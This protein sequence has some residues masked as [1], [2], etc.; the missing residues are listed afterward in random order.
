MP[1][2]AQGIPERLLFESGFGHK[3]P[4]MV[5]FE[6]MSIRMRH[7]SS[8]SKNRRSHHALKNRNIV[9][10]E[11]GT[12]RLP[13]R[14]DEATGTYRGK[15]I[16][17]KRVVKEKKKDHDKRLAEHKHEHPEGEKAPIHTEKI[18]DAPKKAGVLG[19]M[20]KDRARSRSGFGG[21]A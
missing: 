16:V 14:V 12:L 11:D 3:N 21:G 17:E 13:H 5:G 1:A 18:E 20:M 19:R 7:T 6:P 2:A 15:Q 8:H 10:N 9:K 4:Y